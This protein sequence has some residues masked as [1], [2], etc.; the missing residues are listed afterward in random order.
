[1]LRKYFFVTYFI[2]VDKNLSFTKT[3]INSSPPSAVYMRQGTGAALVQVMAYRLFGAK[4]LS[5]PVLAYCQLDSWEQLSLK[6]E[7]EF[8]H[9]HSRKCIWKCRLPEW[10]SFCPGRDEL[11]VDISVIHVSFGNTHSVTYDTLFAY[12]PFDWRHGIG[13]SYTSFCRQIRFGFTGKFFV[14]YGM[15]VVT[16]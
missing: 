15:Y 1:M 10:R 5:E 6:S 8:Y 4:P 3:W 9:F 7:S 16:S 12:C 2:K 13:Y 11:K 14:V